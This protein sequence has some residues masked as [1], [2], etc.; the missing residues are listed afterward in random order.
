MVSSTNA[1][2]RAGAA[3]PSPP[4]SPQGVPILPPQNHLCPPGPLPFPVEHLKELAPFG[5]PGKVGGKTTGM[6]AGGHQLPG[7]V[8][9]FILDRRDPPTKTQ[10][11]TEHTLAALDLHFPG[12]QRKPVR[13]KGPAAGLTPCVLEP[14]WPGALSC[15]SSPARAPSGSEGRGD[16]YPR[17]VDT[18]GSKGR[19]SHHRATQTADTAQEARKQPS[20]ASVRDG[21]WPK[22]RRR[23]IVLSPSSHKHQ[24]D[25]IR[26][27]KAQLLFV[28]SL[29]HV[30]L[31]SAPWTAAHQANLSPLSSEF[32]QTHVP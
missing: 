3:W 22:Q 12:G 13:L 24:A 28:K 4:G 2:R 9:K 31:F 30:Q 7:P 17:W 19:F 25:S 1:D 14:A 10:N 6:A 5:I 8:D 16:C 27:I 23:S 21:L 26:R 29:S 18:S 15:K 32:A 20:L 11:R